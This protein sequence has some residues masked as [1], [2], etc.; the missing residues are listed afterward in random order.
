MGG[1]RVPS[2]G[3]DRLVS[4]CH[5][6]LAGGGLSS[7]M[8]GA[9]SCLSIHTLQQQ[10]P[11][12]PHCTLL[13][14]LPVLTLNQLLKAGGVQRL[15]PGTPYHVQTLSTLLKRGRSAEELTQGAA[16]SPCN[17]PHYKADPANSR[18]AISRCL[19]KFYLLL[20][21]LQAALARALAAGDRTCVHACESGAGGAPAPSAP[22]LSWVSLLPA[23]CHRGIMHAQ[24]GDGGLSEEVQ[25]PEEAE[26][27]SHAFQADCKMRDQVI[28]GFV[29]RVGKGQG[30]GSGSAV[31]G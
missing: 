14:Q 29:P 31:W 9:G 23:P 18:A 16:S 22:A 13:L 17:P 5:A 26:G 25:C 20:L 6:A 21:L 24:A 28:G 3:G 30:G 27:N 15:N 19:L 11:R 1:T 12:H 2:L 10:S 7:G 8:V 4:W